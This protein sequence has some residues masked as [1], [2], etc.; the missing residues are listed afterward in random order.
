[1]QIATYV[2]AKS[3]KKI[4]EEQLELEKTKRE[5]YLLSSSINSFIKTTLANMMSK[6]SKFKYPTYEEMMEN[7]EENTPYHYDDL[8]LKV[9]RGKAFDY[10]LKNKEYMENNK[11]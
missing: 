6:N 2:V 7:E 10:L 9:E 8:G 1:M 11:K 4:L 5:I 3:D